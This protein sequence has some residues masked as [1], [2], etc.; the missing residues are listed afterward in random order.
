MLKIK[1]NGLVLEYVQNQ[2]EEISLEAFRRLKL[3][4]EQVK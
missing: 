2:T 4:L 3:Y 1:Q